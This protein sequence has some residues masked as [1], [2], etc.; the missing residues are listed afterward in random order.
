MGQGIASNVIGTTG[1][2]GKVSRGVD[3]VLTKLVLEVATYKTDV[4]V[5]EERSGSIGVGIDYDVEPSSWVDNSIRGRCGDSDAGIDNA[6]E[7]EGGEK[8][9]SDRGGSSFGGE[10][11]HFEDDVEM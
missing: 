2:G 7:E 3:D 4:D 10:V 5:V 1:T 11:N 9:G 8:C 6:S